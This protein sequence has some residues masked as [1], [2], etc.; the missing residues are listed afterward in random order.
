VLKAIADPNRLAILRALMQQELT[1]TELAA[2]VGM[3]QPHVSHHLA[4]LRHAGLVD[5]ERDRNRVLNRLHPDVQDQLSKEPNV[6]EL[7]C[8]RLELRPASTN[9]P[10]LR[11]RGE[12]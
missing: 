5:H 10:R 3:A 9:K 2:A 12:I 1:V 6:I 7:D 8:C 11:V 4:I